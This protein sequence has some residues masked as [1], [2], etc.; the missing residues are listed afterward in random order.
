MKNNR[1]LIT[2]ASALFVLGGTFFAIR[3]AQ[4]YRPSRDGLKSTGLLN[5]NSFP[6]G[7][8]VYINGNLTTATD[9][10]LNLSPGEYEVE[11]KKDGFST[12]KK[13][14]HL[15]KELVAQ[16]NALLFPIAPGLTP[17]TYTGAS[18]IH[19]SPDGQKLLFST[20]SASAE[21]SNGLYVLDLSDNPLALQRGPRQIARSTSTWPLEK[22]TYLWSPDADQVLVSL[23]N[24]N[25][26]LDTNKMNDMDTVR[27]VTITLPET[28]ATWED[29]LYKKEQTRLAK[30]PREIIDIAT[31]SAKNIFV[32]PDLKRVMYTATAGA[33]IADNIVPSIQ[34]ASTQPQ[35]RDIQPGNTYV[36]DR[37]EDRNFLVYSDGSTMATT[38][39]AK[40]LSPDQKTTTKKTK[41]P[42][43]APLTPTE[44]N[45]VAQ[46]IDNLR[47]HYSGLYTNSPQ[48]LPDSKH[49]ILHSSNTISIVEY[50][51]TNTVQVYTGPFS[52]GF[53]YPWPNGTKLMILTNF[54]QS[55][56]V[57]ENIYALSLR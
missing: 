43:T 8:S 36:Y 27:D 15:E 6:T 54:N 26:I 35:S 12:W 48:W 39:D 29:Q 3:Y 5:A 9:S 25:V 28:L 31:G 30:F 41:K 4:G 13:K 32:S 21:R 18:A 16:T 55:A 38:Q 11:I 19:P 56:I 40:P 7:A 10:T 50:D 34:A 22:A 53:V 49:V 20:A 42:V 17:L 14:M 52:L 46:V 45:E 37:R 51:G 47:R 1:L 24:K 23:G 2:I 44:K 33:H 57:P